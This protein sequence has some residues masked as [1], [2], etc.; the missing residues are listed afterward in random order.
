MSVPMLVGFATGLSPTPT[1]IPLAI[2]AHVLG[3]DAPRPLLIG[4]LSAATPLRWR[5]G[6]TARDNPPSR[7]RTW[8]ALA[9][10]ALLWAVMGLALLPWLVGVPLLVLA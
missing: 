5:A 1:P 9:L 8:H 2:A 10:G 7:L 3:E 6:R 4:R